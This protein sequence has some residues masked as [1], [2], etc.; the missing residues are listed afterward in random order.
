MHERRPAAQIVGGAVRAIRT[1][2]GWTQRELGQRARMS[3][4]MV[5][6]V[7][8]GRV[9]DL[10]FARAQRMLEA[11][12]A[13]LVVSV[14]APYLGDRERQRDPVHARCSA[15]VVARLQRAGWVVATEVEIGGDRS[16][17]WIDVL[18]YHPSLAWLLVIEIKTE[19]RDLG[20]IERTLGWYTREAMIAAQRFGWR[21]ERSLGCLLLLAT[22]AN[23][24]R[25]RS[26]REPLTHGFPT[27][28]HEIASL[29][30]HGT[31]PPRSGYAV[32]MIDP[33]SRRETWLRSLRL[34]GR[35]SL[36]PYA[37]YAGF[38]RRAGHGGRMTRRDRA[39]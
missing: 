37:D 24:V 31:A 2:I 9:D 11:M 39:G 32:A 15:H 28:A 18:A 10:T 1:G 4:A 26:N 36:A 3:Q 12:G 33:T 13:R 22:E 21:P 8:N 29:V 30:N 27:R 25:A 19:I 23:D 14:D 6:A 7:E 5:C 38:M 16:R 20:A 35:R 17:G 34:D